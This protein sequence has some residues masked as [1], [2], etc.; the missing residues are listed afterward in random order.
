MNTPVTPDNISGA[1]TGPLSARPTSW[2]IV[3]CVD[4]QAFV[5]EVEGGV[6]RAWKRVF[7]AESG[8]SKYTIC[9]GTTANDRVKLGEWDTF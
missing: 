5:E 2:V 4:V 7:V 1:A 9:G 6:R 3:C 8:D